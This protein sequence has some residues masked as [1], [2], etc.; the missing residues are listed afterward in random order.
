MRPIESV[1]PQGTGGEALGI[2]IDGLKE[3]LRI[4]HKAEAQHVQISADTGG[5]KTTIMM[6]LAFCWS[7]LSRTG[8]FR[9][10]REVPNRFQ[11]GGKSVE[12]RSCIRLSL[13]R[14]LKHRAARV[15]A[16]GTR[17]PLPGCA[18]KI[19]ILVKD[20]AAI[21]VEAIPV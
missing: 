20:E 14:Q 6:R 10:L 17:A 8:W 7:Q 19:P 11:G 5:G 15:W 4:P 2:K 18:V 21:G 13:G 16:V 9:Q 1:Q 12:V 3:M